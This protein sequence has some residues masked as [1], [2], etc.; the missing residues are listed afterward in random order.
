MKKFTHTL[1]N[2]HLLK[3]CGI[4]FSELDKSIYLKK[5]ISRFS[6]A[7]TSVISHLF[8][9]IEYDMYGQ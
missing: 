9:F 4:K 5:E 2:I 6:R 7:R 3:Q 1:V 8:I